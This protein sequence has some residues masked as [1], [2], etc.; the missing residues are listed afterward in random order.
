MGGDL[1]RISA[2]PDDL[3]HV[4]LGR[5]GSAPVV[6]RTAVLSRRWRHVWRHS[7]S[8]TFEEDRDRCLK[9][10]GDLAGFVDWAL[11]QRG[12]ANMES[13]E[14]SFDRKGRSASPEKVNEWLRYAAG[15]VV[16]S[17]NV[18]LARAPSDGYD[19]PAVELPSHGGRT[20]TISLSLTDRRLQL[21]ATTT[22]RYEALTELNLWSVRFAA[23]AAAS[24]SGSNVLGDFVMSCCPRLRRLH[25]SGEGLS[26]LV[27]RTEVLEELSIH[28]R[29]T[30]DLETMDVVAPNLR[31]VDLDLD[32]K[33]V[34][35]IVAPRLREFHGGF[36]N[37]TQGYKPQDLDIR[38]LES[39]RLVENIWLEM[40]GKYHRDAD[41]CSLLENC[42]AVEHVDVRVLHSGF[43]HPHGTT[44]ELVDMTSSEG[45]RPFGNVRTMAIT[46]HLPR[47]DLVASISSLLT[48]CPRLTSLSVHILNS[49]NRSP[50]K[51][52][53]YA[54]PDRC[55]VVHANQLLALGALQ[56][57][58]MAGFD[59]TDEEMHL[60][61]TLFGSSKN[62]IERVRIQ[63]KLRAPVNK[64]KR[65]GT[66]AHKILHQLPSC[67]A[68]ADLQGRWNL[69]KKEGGETFTWTCDWTRTME[70]SSACQLAEEENLR[71][72][73]PAAASSSSSGRKSARSVIRERPNTS[74]RRSIL[75]FFWCLCMLVVDRV[76][77]FWRSSESSSEETG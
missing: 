64:K 46:S 57:V 35:R 10:K 43:F 34:G 66:Y 11:A 41:V 33:V 27:L 65:L 16:G 74:Y 13:L 38:G 76:K 73:M 52:S 20:A 26:Q 70:S 37:D 61:G 32:D 49:G 50:W 54:L 40:H 47:Q 29:Y 42:P 25:F 62:S 68:A 17:V 45:K 12:D 18:S 51:C 58:E 6:T 7:R 28:C 39:V 3:L 21:P 2:L 36:L 31:V 4:I 5:V 30:P 59:G 19:E 75:L 9:K 60:L 8:L 77:Q 24:G 67:C 53:C 23:G 56:E 22:A 71:A 44:D 69:G 63:L 15:R 14:I 48:R 55:T 72:A 1:D